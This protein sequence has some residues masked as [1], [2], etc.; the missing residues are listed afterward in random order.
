M[1][2]STAP[3][4]HIPTIEHPIIL[5][6]NPALVVHHVSNFSIQRGVHRQRFT[7][8]SFI[9]QAPQKRFPLVDQC[10]SLER[11]LAFWLGIECLLGLGE[12]IHNGNILLF[13]KI[14][15]RLGKNS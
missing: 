2:P 11:V 3:T 1:V 14:D 12:N 8:Q 6:M 5:S 13:A 9:Q 7:K 10:K 4:I 15:Y